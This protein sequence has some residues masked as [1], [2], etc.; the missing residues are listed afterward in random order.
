V[1]I[2]SVAAFLDHA[3]VASQEGLKEVTFGRPVGWLVQNQSS[4]DPPRF[5]RT[6]SP[7]QPENNPTHLLV[8]PLVLDLA[9][10]YATLCVALLA[11]GL[12]VGSR[13]PI[14]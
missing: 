14:D 9:I 3:V 2:T 7:L 8:V 4:M 13:E 11:L 1:I 10:V 5:P 12:G 6:M